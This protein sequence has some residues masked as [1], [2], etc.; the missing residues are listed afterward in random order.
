[1]AEVL[2]LESESEV[3]VEVEEWEVV[4][5]GGGALGMES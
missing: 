5:E 4:D 2:S 1:M 3:D